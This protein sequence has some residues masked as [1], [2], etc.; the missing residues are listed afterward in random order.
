MPGTFFKISKLDDYLKA[1]K[2]ILSNIKT[3]KAMQT[4]R[5]SNINKAMNIDK[6]FAAD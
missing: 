1:D 5:H 2:S 3:K 4:K 6:Y